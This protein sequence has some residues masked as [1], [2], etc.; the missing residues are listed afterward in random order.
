MSSAWRRSSSVDT[1]VALLLGR[2][3]RLAGIRERDFQRGDVR[4]AEA[5]R[6]VGGFVVK[7]LGHFQDSAPGLNVFVMFLFCS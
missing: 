4:Q 7:G 2:F 1:F 3:G 5:F 6:D